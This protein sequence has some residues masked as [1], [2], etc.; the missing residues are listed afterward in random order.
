MQRACNDQYGA[1]F[2]Y[3]AKVRPPYNAYSWRC[4]KPWDLDSKGIDV[5]RE[6]V[7][8]YGAGAHAGLWNWRNPYTWFCQR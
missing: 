4:T 8:Q 2:G 1:Q 3:V 6:C 7:V 5:N